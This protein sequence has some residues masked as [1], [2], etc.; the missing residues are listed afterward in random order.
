M[1]ADDIIGM[2]DPDMIY[3]ILAHQWININ[4]KNNCVNTFDHWKCIEYC[5]K[6]RSRREINMISKR[7]E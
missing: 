1:T 5:E 4:T 2:L 7:K 3:C 6:Y